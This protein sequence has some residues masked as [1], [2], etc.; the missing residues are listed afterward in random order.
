M[1]RALVAA[2]ADVAAAG[3]NGTV[4]RHAVAAA[5]SPRH[6]CGCHGDGGRSRRLHR[7]VHGARRC[8][9]RAPSLV[10]GWQCRRCFAAA[11]AL[12]PP[13]ATSM[14][15]EGSWVSDGS[16]VFW[17]C[18]GRARG[19]GAAAGGGIAA[20]PLH[21]GPLFPTLPMTTGVRDSAGGDVGPRR[22]IVLVTVKRPRCV[23]IVKSIAARQTRKL[24]GAPAGASD[25]TGQF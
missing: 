16:A 6:R 21:T 25:A 17:P 1:V 15:L 20:A 8:G 4:R 18:V 22:C 5:G 23:C 24:E 9:V 2:S 11:A 10:A 13:A 12:A 14:A 7:R 3:G 19:Q